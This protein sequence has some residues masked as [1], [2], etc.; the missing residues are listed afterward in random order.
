M[1]P[2]RWSAPSDE[3]AWVAPWRRAVERAPAAAPSRWRPGARAAGAEPRHAAVLV[4]V[5][6]HRPV[7]AAPGTPAGDVLLTERATGLRNHAGQVSFP[8]GG[9][10][11]GDA[12][13][14]ATALRE[15][16]EEVGLDPAGVEVLG[17]LP[18]VWLP[19]SQRQVTAVVAWWR[20]PHPLLRLDEREVA[21]VARA[22]VAELVDPARRVGVVHPG[23]GSGAGFLVADMFVWGFTA[24]LLAW[25]L[26]LADLARPWDTSP[27]VTWEGHP[28]HG[29]GLDAGPADAGRPNAPAGGGAA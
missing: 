21:R 18:P 14:A 1:S 23:G 9:R 6:P 15:A 26:D 16:E 17:E 24:G 22:P 10:E 28:L 12:D 13:D 7:A 19:P 20:R 8:G 29:E 11:V 27:R 25:L 5:G 4:L 3:P 2:A